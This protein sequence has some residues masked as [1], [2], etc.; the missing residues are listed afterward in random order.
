MHT[1]IPYWDTPPLQ[2]L[3]D[4]MEMCRAG[5]FP[6]RCSTGLTLFGAMECGCFVRKTNITVSI[7][8]ECKVFS[9]IPYDWTE[10]TKMVLL[11]KDQ[12]IAKFVQLFLFK[13]M[14]P[15]FNTCLPK[16]P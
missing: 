14:L 5:G 1:K 8:F 15:S 4:F 13:A 11:L 2:L 9:I 7:M 3:C 6:L 16:A 10:R 12:M